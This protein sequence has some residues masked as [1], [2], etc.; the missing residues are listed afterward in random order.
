MQFVQL[1]VMIRTVGKAVKNE[2][3]N[4]KVLVSVMDDKVLGGECTECAG[5]GRT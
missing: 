5:S 3:E 1:K 2:S 4:K